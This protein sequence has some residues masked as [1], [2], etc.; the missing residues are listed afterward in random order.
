MSVGLLIVAH[1]RIA[2]V[3][4]EVAVQLLGQCPL[5]LGVLPVASDCDPE[6]VKVRA[7]IEVERLDEGEGVLVLTDIFGGTASNVAVSLKEDRRVEVVA[8][9]NLPMLVRVLNYAGLDLP[10]LAEKAITGGRDGVFNCPA[11]G[12]R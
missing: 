5:P 3:F 10:K 7:R 1:E 12:E 4:A 9:I 2:P 8:G 6:D 11:Q